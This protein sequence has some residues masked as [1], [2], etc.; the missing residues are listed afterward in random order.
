MKPH[1]ADRRCMKPYLAN[2]RPMKLYPTNRRLM[3]PQILKEIAPG[4]Q[5]T[6]C[7]QAM[8]RGNQGNQILDHT[9]LH[10]EGISYYFVLSFLKVLTSSALLSGLTFGGGFVYRK[11]LPPM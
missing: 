5:M 1:P 10:Q 9:Q 6:K 11:S 4:V 3:K 7:H 8:Q 2:R